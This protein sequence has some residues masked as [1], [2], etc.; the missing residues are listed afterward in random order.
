MQAFKGAKLSDVPK[1]EIRVANVASVPQLSPLRYPGGK[2]WLIPHIKPWLRQCGDPIRNLFE[3]FAGGG[4]ISLYAVMEGAARYC[5]MREIDRDVAAFWHTVLNN[6]AELA[7]RIE[8]FELTQDS[9]T[10]L[11]QASISTVEDRGFR[12][13]VLNRVRR[14]GILAAGAS[15]CRRGEN[16]RGI[17]SRWYP[18]TLAGRIRNIHKRSDFIRFEESDGIKLIRTLRDRHRGSDVAL[19]I[20]P[21]YTAGGKNAGKR[22]YKHHHV[23]HRELFELVVNSGVN[24]M[25]TYDASEEIWELVCEHR[26][27]TVSVYMKNTHNRKLRELIIT[28]FEVEEFV[29]SVPTR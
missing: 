5:T 20:D 14:G 17:S 1:S 26:L 13:F 4:I 29:E 10:K 7:T 21:P 27:H 3:P 18:K 24:F 16:N 12:T 15:Y 22:L 28:N 23:D 11:M 25:M 9:V 6:G 8:K 2:T 19:F